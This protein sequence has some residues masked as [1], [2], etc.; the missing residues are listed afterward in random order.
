MLIQ[1]AY[2]NATRGYRYGISDWY[3]PYTE[4][5]GRLFRDFQQEYGRCI[6]KVY[7]D[8]KKGTIQVG[9][10]FQKRVLYED[11]RPDWTGKYRKDDYYIREVWVSFAN[12]DRTAMDISRKARRS[13]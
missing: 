9:W 8:T 10:V 3:E 12:D 1:E 5:V 7:L 2:F 6:S 4:N 11:A 13:A